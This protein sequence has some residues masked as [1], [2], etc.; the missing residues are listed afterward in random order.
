MKRADA[1]RLGIVIV[2]AALAFNLHGYVKQQ[3]GGVSGGDPYNYLN[4]AKSITAG[5]NPF[6]GVKRLPGYPLLLIPTITNPDID[7]HQ[8]MR[9]LSGLAAAGTII[10]VY[11]LAR[12]LALPW[13]VQL[14]APLMLAFQKDFFATSLRPEP[15]TLFAML[16]VASLVLFFY[17]RKPWQQVLFGIVLGYATMVR[18]EGFVLAIIFF[19]AVIW[20]RVLSRRILPP[21]RSVPAFPR[22]E[23]WAPLE[24]TR[25]GPPTAV[26]P[27]D[28]HAIFHMFIPALLIVL[29]FFIHNA[30]TFGNPFQTAYFEEEGVKLQPVDSFHAFKDATTSTLGVLT[31]MWKPTWTQLERLMPYDH[32]FVVGTLL[33]GIFWW[34]AVI[35]RR[36]HRH[37]FLALTLI[38]LS[39]LVGIA[40]L[41]GLFVNDIHEARAVIPMITA[42]LLWLAPIMLLPTG[43]WRGTLVVAVLISQI[44]IATWFHPFPKHYQQAYPLLV[45]GYVTVLFAFVPGT[46]FVSQKIAVALAIPLYLVW[47]TPFALAA[48]PLYTDLNELIDSNNHNG[49]LDSVLYRA[50]RV[51]NR[52]PG[53]H[54]YTIDNLPARL[55]HKPDNLRFVDTGDDL[56]AVH[57]LVVVEVNGRAEHFDVPAREIATFASEGKDEILYRTTVY[58]LLD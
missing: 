42:G 39:S 29:P 25:G 52:Y 55:Y 13:P 22:S 32:A 43:R 8:Y 2:I 17:A 33:V 58:E 45:L 57:T 28:H 11:F 51:S 53:V 34:I 14:A 49:A 9:T 20:T 36:I 19:V 44:L 12:Q 5:E 6:A 56:S 26:P 23:A 48:I 21:L 3:M 31:S 40:W 54:A 1:A 7:V 27:A 35:Q 47:L 18:Q 15:Y 16:L 30:F 46:K 24:I 4:I 37:S 38:S 41:S 50:A 10:L